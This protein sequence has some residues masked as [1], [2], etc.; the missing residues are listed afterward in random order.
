M[1]PILTSFIPLAIF[2]SPSSLVALKGDLN[3]TMLFPGNEIT[4][5]SGD[6]WRGLENTLQTLVLAENSIASLPLDAFTGL[7]MLETLDL[8]G[9]HLSVI[10]PGV[11]RDGMSRLNRVCF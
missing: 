9:N 10:D 7:P 3:R 4:D 5:I 6:N 2:R 8:N 11:F 1:I